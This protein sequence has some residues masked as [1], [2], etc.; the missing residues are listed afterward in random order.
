MY[1]NNKGFTVIELVFVLAVLS[2]LSAVAVIKYQKIVATAELD[3]EAMGVYQELTGIRPFSMK[4]DK[5][6][7]VVFKNK[8]F[9]VD[10]YT[11]MDTISLSKSIGFAVAS[12]GPSK[13]PF[14]HAI[15]SDSGAKLLWKD[16]LLIK[17]DAIGTIDTGYVLISSS[18]LKKT[19][20]YIGVNGG[21]QGMRL[22]KW[23]GSSWIK[24]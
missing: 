24:Q 11:K 10:R 21:F 19:T 3:K 18:K 7:K 22:Y 13:T 14:Q 23:T 1:K 2:V 9:I 6:G 15:A 5:M 12:G 4:N 20:Y 17:R 8:K 16:S